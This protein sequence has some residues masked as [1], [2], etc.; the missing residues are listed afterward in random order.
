M[1]EML[2]DAKTV[3]LVTHSLGIVEKVCTRAIWLQEGTIR[4]DGDPKEAVALYK[5]SVKRYRNMKKALP[6]KK[7]AR[8]QQAVKQ[9]GDGKYE[10]AE[11]LLEEFLREYPHDLTVM[12]QYAEIA[13]ESQN[14]EQAKQRWE[15]VLKAAEFIGE[16]PPQR[17]E[18]RLKEIAQEQE[19][20]L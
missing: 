13:E 2:A 8:L 15:Q 19:M 17:A 16:E 10:I 20:K 5:E 7:D 12:T 9:F 3:I 18:Q 14:W 1:Q 4:Y 11:G 6:V